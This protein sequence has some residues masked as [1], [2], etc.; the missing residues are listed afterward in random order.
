MILKGDL[1]GLVPSLPYLH[2][3]LSFAFCLQPIYSPPGTLKIGIRSC[4]SSQ[5]KN[6][7]IRS[8]MWDSVCVHYSTRR[9]EAQMR[10]RGGCT[11][12]LGYLCDGAHIQPQG[13]TLREG[14]QADVQTLRFNIQTSEACLCWEKSGWQWLWGAW[15]APGSQRGSVFFFFLLSELILQGTCCM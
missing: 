10:S 12:Q 2:E 9:R 1:E 8:R 6:S 13:C 5:L 4:H 7:P 15:R 3:C 14:N 11:N